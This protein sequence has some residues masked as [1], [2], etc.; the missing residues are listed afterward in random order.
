[1]YT[2]DEYMNGSQ[3]TAFMIGEFD[4][5]LDNGEE[6]Y[7]EEKS[8][9]PE[10]PLAHGIFI[11]VAAFLLILSLAHVITKHI[12][13][14]PLAD[15]EKEYLTA[16]DDYC[17][18]LAASLGELCDSSVFYMLQE[19]LS[20]LNGVDTE[21]KYIR[22]VEAVNDKAIAADRR[23][24]YYTAERIWR[25]L[26]ES[27][28]SVPAEYLAD[29]V[30]RCIQSGDREGYKKYRNFINWY[31]N[32]AVR[33]AIYMKAL[34]AYSYG[35]TVAGELF[36]CTEGYRDSDS[37]AMAIRASAELEDIDDG[38][39]HNITDIYGG[40][41]VLS[42]FAPADRL[43]N[44]PAMQFVS[45]IQGSWRC[46]GSLLFHGDT[47]SDSSI[48]RSYVF[49]NGRAGYCLDG[50]LTYTDI[51]YKNGEYYLNYVDEDEY[52]R[53]NGFSSGNYFAFST[54]FIFSG[55][56]LSS[57]YERTVEAQ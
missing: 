10:I 15:A 54:E 3:D 52:T 17:R 20:T 31:G 1:M 2:D 39:L 11:C 21:G 8:S 42:G 51:Y 7:R 45:N 41:H 13:S 30:T 47:K 5:D 6:Y 16:Q 46:V 18:E 12:V 55:N 23:G 28:Y 40:L 48:D 43:M 26:M 34:E 36:A 22:E 32:D 53:V 57:A 50:E 14:D 19:R 4:D 27:G 24:D 38:Q 29:A 56:R 35:E 33:E 49:D 25:C 37:F 44:E 9:E